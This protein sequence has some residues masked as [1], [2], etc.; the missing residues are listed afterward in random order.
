MHNNN[1]KNI[2]ENYLVFNSKVFIKRDWEMHIY[3]LQSNILLF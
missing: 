3:I 1:R 2:I